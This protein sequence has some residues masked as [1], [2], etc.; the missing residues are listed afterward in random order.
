MAALGSGDRLSIVELGGANSCFLDAILEGV[1]PVSYDVVDTNEYG[2]SLL[3][4]RLPDNAVVRLH[5]QSVL[6]LRLEK[7]ADVVFS[8]GLIE[9]FDPEDTQ[10]AILAHFEVV[11]PGGLVILTFP[12]PTVLYRVA[13]S[14]LEI[15]GLWRFP[16]ERP[17][18]REEV[19]ATV[20]QRGAIVREQLL[21]PLILTQHMMVVRKGP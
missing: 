12:T 20:E 14:A 4:R 6:A 7:P 21:W 8:A 9:H 2:L 1:A 17:L 16:D 11:R 3:A 18:A 10:R 15:A 13:R 19:A 5:R